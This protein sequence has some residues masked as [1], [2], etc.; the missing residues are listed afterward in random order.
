MVKPPVAAAGFARSVF[1]SLESAALHQQ[2]ALQAWPAEASQLR[3]HAEQLSRAADGL[4]TE[5]AIVGPRPAET[6]ALHIS[7]LAL[8]AFEIGRIVGPENQDMLEQRAA[9]RLQA[10]GRDSQSATAAASNFHLDLLIVQ[11]LDDAR[12]QGR[13]LQDKELLRRVNHVLADQSRPALSLRTLQRRRAA[14][15]DLPPWFGPKARQP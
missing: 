4:L 11:I 15:S 12:S 6:L 10:K 13:D 5:L 1:D 9:A 8:A 7:Q 3:E 2:A 14:L